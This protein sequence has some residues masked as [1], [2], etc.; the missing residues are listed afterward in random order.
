MS[1]TPSRTARQRTDASGVTQITVPVEG[2]SCAACATRIGKVLGKLD[3]VDEASVNYATH[4]AAISYDPSKVDLDQMRAVVEKAGYAL[5]EDVDDDAADAERGR[6]L[7]RNLVVGLLFTVP[8]LAISMTPALMFPG[9]QWVAWALATPVVVYAGREFHRNAWINARHGAVSMDTLVSL[10]T[11][12]AYVWSVVALLFLG[13]GRHG[14]M[15]LNVAGLPEVYF[16]TAAAIIT[17]ILLGRFFEHRAKGRSSQA[18]RRLL[19]LGAKTAT[20]EDG[21]EIPVEDLAPGMRFVVRP[22]E[23]IATDGSV[24]GGQ[25]AVDTSMITGEPVPV[26]VGPGDDVVGG[27]VNEG[28]RLVVEA[29]AVG[30]DTVLSQIVELVARAQG[31]KAP[32]QSLVDKVSSVFVPTVITIAAITFGIWIAQGLGLSESITRA[33]AVLVIAC[34]CALGLA[35]PTAIMVGTGR[36]ASLGVLIKGAQTLE[37]TRTVD[38]IVL[39]KTGTVT[40]GRMTLADVVVADG[41]DA[42]QV[43]ALVGAA[44]DASEHP[45]ARAIAAGARE[46]LNGIALPEVSAF[47]NQP[48]LGVRATV[49]GH[50]VVVGRDGLVAGADADADGDARVPAA[51]TEAV[52]GIEAQGRTAVLAAVDGTPVA[53][54]AVADTVK[55]TSRQAIAAFRKLGLRTILL[56][57]DNATT[58]RAVAD[59]VGIDEV[60][61]E[62][63][64]ADKVDVVRRLQDDGRIVAMVGDG[65]NDAPALAQADLGLSMG[66][67]TDVAIEAGDVTLVSGDLRA[68]ADAV[69]LSRRTLATIKGNLVWAFGYN[70]L[71]IPLAA[72]GLLNPMIAAAAMGFSSVFVVT[73]SL[74]LRDFRGLRTGE[75]STAQRVEKVAIRL[76]F[77]ALIAAV[78]YAG[79]VFQ[80]SLLPGRHVDVGL[81]DATFPTTL[82]VAPGE[83]VTFVLHND[84]TQERSFHVGTPAELD[85]ARAA[86]PGDAAT[87]APGTMVPAGAT[88]RFTWRLPSEGLANLRYGELEQPADTGR[89][90]PR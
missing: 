87:H 40:E 42:D 23:R 27:T 89:F 21:T 9:W 66:T 47:A 45:V 75:V 29:Q 76:G 59:E 3:G 88:V 43:L 70:V 13:A 78:I 2:M 53:V 81:G 39:D 25:S 86:G 34:P 90:V 44:E 74:R 26:E 22:G 52:R 31:G 1:P 82:V 51:L 49:D 33:V 41:A 18:I 79:V 56:T 14:G 4:R 20:L 54:L 32:V 24:V 83:K 5:P 80:R 62:V 73:N 69:A 46:R 67:G 12:V 57:G 7:T 8:L 15:R 48:G 19:E 50:E 38:T 64:P 84:G 17:F 65:V 37:A 58:A 85:A 11:S 30:G 35:T 6:R 71:A 10:G 36:G 68:A 28:G 55:A 61:A 16:E 77:V 63:L 72:V 60:I